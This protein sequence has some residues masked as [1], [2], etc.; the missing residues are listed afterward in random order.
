MGPAFFCFQPAAIRPRMP[1]SPVSRLA[2]VRA[3][4]II[5]AWPA[6][7]SSPRSRS[8]PIR[9]PARFAG[10]NRDDAQVQAGDEFSNLI[11]SST[12][13][14]HSLLPA[15]ASKQSLRAQPP[16]VEPCRHRLRGLGSL[17]GRGLLGTGFAFCLGPLPIFDIHWDAR[18]WSETVFQPNQRSSNKII[19]SV[20]TL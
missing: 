6:T 19:R 17:I 20:S 2:N 1:E 15:A 14:R 13:Q 3:T 11:K 5:N 8:T 4:P 16:D 9:K 12:C 18:S 10:S 7:S